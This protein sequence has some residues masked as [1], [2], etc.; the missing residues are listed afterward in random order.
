MKKAILF[1]VLL[2]L[3]VSTIMAMSEDTVQVSV[4]V[5]G[6]VFALSLQDSTGAPW[7]G[8]LDFGEV[9]PGESA[10]P[11]SALV[12]AAC[13]SNTG[14]SWF[15]NVSATEL[16]ADNSQSVLPASMLRVYV[17]D[18]AEQGRPSLP[19]VRHATGNDPLP[20]RNT[21]MVI[22][23]SNSLG[24]AGFDGGWGTYL[25]VGF[26]L[27]VPATQRQG[28]YAGLIRFTMTE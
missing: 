22:Y 10:Y 1:F 25:P 2:C 9:A 15:L 13:Q 19:G 6:T 7:S 26:G 20:M 4:E 16:E 3:L 23:S 17:G 5:V 28:N 11:D 18:P 8:D 21:D 14:R 24:D 12:V 27:N